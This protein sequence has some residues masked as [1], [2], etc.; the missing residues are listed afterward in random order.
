MTITMTNTSIRYV[1]KK[2]R[3]NNHKISATRKMMRII[4]PTKGDSHYEDI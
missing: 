3:K 4:N 2:T 1:T